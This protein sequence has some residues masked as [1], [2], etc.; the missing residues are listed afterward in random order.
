M[1]KFKKGEF[2]IYKNGESHQIVEIKDIF[3][4]KERYRKRQDGLFGK[5]TD[6]ETYEYVSY[7]VY[8]HTGD[9]AAV[10]AENLLIKIDNL[11]AFEIKRRRVDD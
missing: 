1:S 2:A 7:A 10:C 11:Y 5:P 4:N 8:S 9:T 6:D 3:V